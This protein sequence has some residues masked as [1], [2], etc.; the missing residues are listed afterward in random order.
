MKE[1]RIVTVPE[2]FHDNGEQRAANTQAFVPLLH[3][4]PVYRADVP[5]GFPPKAGRDGG[6]TT[7][8]NEQAPLEKLAFLV[9]VH[10]VKIL[11]H[12]GRKFVRELGGIKMHGFPHVQLVCPARS[13]IIRRRKVREG[14]RIQRFAHHE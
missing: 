5:V 8:A 9:G 14:R 11:G 10:L 6:I 12:K 1:Y 4:E 3:L 2:T 13:D 7:I